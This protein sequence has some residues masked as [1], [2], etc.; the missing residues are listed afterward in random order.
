MND[1]ERGLVEPALANI[2][3]R[4]SDAAVARFLGWSD[5][6]L[7]TGG[8]VMWTMRVRA[9]GQ[10]ESEGEQAEMKADDGRLPGITVGEPMP[11]SWDAVAGGVGR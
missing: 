1:M 3:G 9:M 5:Y 6:L 10:R 4:T 8:L 2:V 11:L 7:L